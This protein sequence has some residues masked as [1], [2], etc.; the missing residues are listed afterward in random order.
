M[1]RTF[2]THGINAYNILVKQLQ[3][4]RP[5]ETGDRCMILKGI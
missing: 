2:I 4:K 1:G 5:I 3:G